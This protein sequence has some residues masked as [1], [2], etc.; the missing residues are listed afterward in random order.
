[1]NK[2]LLVFPPV[3]MPE[4]PFLSTAILS[5]YL[6]ERSLDVIQRDLNLEFWL[7]FEESATIH[8]VYRQSQERWQTLSSQKHLER[9]ELALLSK[10]APISKLPEERFL[11]E[12]QHG[13]ISRDV[14][15]SLVQAVSNF[16]I[17]LKQ[18]ERLRAHAEREHQN[19][20]DL[21]YSDISYS[22]YASS[23][24]NL[25]AI[26]GDNPF[27]AYFKRTFVPELESLNPYILGLSIAA[28]NQ[29]VPAFTLAK[30]V[31]ELR[32]ET[33]IVIGGS[34]CTQVHERLAPNLQLFPF[35]DSMSI[36]EGEEPL[37]MLC[38]ALEQGKMPVDIP[39]M[40]LQ[41]AG[42]IRAPRQ[43]FAADMNRLPTPDFEGLPLSDYNF[44]RTLTLQSSRGCYWG[45]CT[46]CSYPFLEPAYKARKSEKIIED[47]RRLQSLYGI[48]D[49]G[50]TDA[51]LS[52][53]FC[54]R[55]SETLLRTNTKVRWA[56][57]ARFEKQFTAELLE[58]MARSGCSFISWGLES[59]NEEI[60]R[61]IEKSI[62][63]QHAE[64]ILSAA[65][66]LG[67][68]SRVLV[69][70]GHPTESVSQALE[71]VEFL[72]RNLPNIHSMS[73]NYYHPEMGTPIEGLA[74]RLGIHLKQ[75]DDQDLAFGY[76][77]GSSLD[78]QERLQIKNLFEEISQ[79][80]ATRQNMAE[81][82]SIA[83]QS[84]RD[85]LGDE[86]SFTV[87]FPSE[88]GRTTLLSAIVDQGGVK[89]RKSFVV[90]EI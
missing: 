78:E 70:Y 38:R 17:D 66:L 52:P 88:D 22:L 25:Q 83:P 2:I 80:L 45:K 46:F 8:E 51:L 48:E 58:Q 7:H 59:G 56:M 10:L 86:S 54:R 63:L 43:H 72:Q 61:L 74:A 23:A 28:I 65:A 44:P 39:N 26:L 15:R 57:F 36:Y 30:L 77:W 21:L 82:S 6:R 20:H 18:V 50:F 1:M 71:T 14:Y 89:H 87:S 68:H 76:Q 19:Y 81:T 16:R 41:Q 31:K 11:F 33:Y 64:S 85:L 73:Y 42:S 79:K 29:V 34:W 12:V 35:I 69:M 3:W 32:P 90:R 24:R 27:R 47:I 4:A 40:Y 5:A 55:F 75:G 67:I 60:L 49:I 84:P 9:H 37:Y 62:S 13:I 53:S